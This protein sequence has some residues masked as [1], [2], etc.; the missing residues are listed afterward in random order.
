MIRNPDFLAIRPDSD[1]NRIDADV[2][3]GDDLSSLS[4]NYIDRVGRR[5]RD[6]DMGTVDGDR[7]RVWAH[8]RRVSDR[9]GLPGDGRFFTTR[10]EAR[11]KHPDGNEGHEHPGVTGSCHVECP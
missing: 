8:K 7:R 10:S 5:V 6:E 1:P 2:D 4:V 9:G 11:T 3:A